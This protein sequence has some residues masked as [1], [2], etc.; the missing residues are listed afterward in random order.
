MEK[1]WYAIQTYSGY[2]QRVKTALE[3]KIRERKM[4]DLFGVILVPAGTVIDL[5]RGKKKSVERRVFPGYVFAQIALDAQS[6]LL[7]H[8]TPKVVG[9]VA[10]GDAPAII[11]DSQVEEII[12]RVEAGTIV[13]TPS[14]LLEVGERVKVIDG[15]FRDFSGTVQAVRS[16]RSRV[17]VAISVFGRPTPVELDFCQVEAA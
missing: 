14:V 9:F 13:P 16:D 1:R 11:P 10:E 17:S 8:S 15:P 2:E 6:W 12:R 5:V 3:R 7:V 4:E